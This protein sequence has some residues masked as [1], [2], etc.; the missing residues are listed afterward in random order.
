MLIL[1][2]NLHKCAHCPKSFAEAA[3]LAS[4]QLTHEQKR[5]HQCS[6]CSKAFKC[7]S[8]LTDHLRIHTGERPFACQK[9]SKTFTQASA[10]RSHTQT[11]IKRPFLCFKCERTFKFQHDLQQHVTQKHSGDENELNG[12]T[13]SKHEPKENSELK[14]CFKCR[15]CDKLF[16]KLC[17]LD[18][19]LRSHSVQNTYSDSSSS[20]SDLTPETDCHSGKTLPESNAICVPSQKDEPVVIRLSTSADDDVDQNSINLQVTGVTKSS[21]QNI[22]KVDDSNVEYVS[23]NI[24]YDVTSKM[25]NGVAQHRETNEPLKITISQKN[26][27]TGKRR[28][29]VKK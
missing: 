27:Q 4:H 5:R 7:K 10:L 17:H 16:S 28:R 26:Q 23:A 9:C 25:F 21:L 24:N 8:H 12:I 1:G 19:H 6:Y 13:C 15:H 14:I 18:E 29:K 2:E 3:E 11:H 20:S 22:S